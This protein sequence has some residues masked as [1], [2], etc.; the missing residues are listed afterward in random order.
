METQITREA[1]SIFGD[2]LKWKTLAGERIPS[3]D[4]LAP[5]LQEAWKAAITCVEEYRNPEMQETIDILTRERDDAQADAE[6]AKEEL[7]AA[8]K[9][10]DEANEANEE[11]DRLRDQI[12]EL[13]EKID[14]LEAQHEDR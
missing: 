12:K 3:W 1:Y 7:K 6:Q 2:A 5:A 4:A 8:E 10:L 13:E 14:H 11:I 9:D